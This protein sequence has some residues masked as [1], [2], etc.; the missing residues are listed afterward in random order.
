MEPK[1][2]IPLYRIRSSQSEKKQPARENSLK[3]K[4]HHQRNFLMEPKQ[5]ILKIVY[6]PR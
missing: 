1:R 3:R 2:E 6:F 4:G 5:E